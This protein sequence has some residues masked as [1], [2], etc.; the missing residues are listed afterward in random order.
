M[1]HC[2]HSHVA[3]DDIVMAARQSKAMLLPPFVL[4]FINCLDGEYPHLSS[5]F[6]S[7][8]WY[9]ISVLSLSMLTSLSRSVLSALRI[10][11]MR[12]F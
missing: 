4:F 3:I 10:L 5:V 7:S 1:G 12:P 6:L 11:S 9:R 8:S 2:M